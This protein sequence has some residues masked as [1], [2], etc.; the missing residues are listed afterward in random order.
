VTPVA[1]SLFDDLA[2]RD[3]AGKLAF[4]RKTAPTAIV[5]R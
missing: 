1:Y 5:E 2:T 3:V 4:W